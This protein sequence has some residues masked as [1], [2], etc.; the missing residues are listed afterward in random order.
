MGLVDLNLGL[1]LWL[2][3]L[4]WGL[5]LLHL[6]LYLGL[7]NSA[8]DLTWV[9][10]LDLSAMTSG[11]DGYDSGTCSSSF[12]TWLGTCCFLPGNAFRTCSSVFRTCWFRPW[13]DLGLVHLHVRFVGLTSDF[14][15]L[16]WDLFFFLLEFTCDFLVLPWDLLVLGLDLIFFHCRPVPLHVAPVDLD[17]GFHLWLVPLHLG[18]AYLDGWSVKYTKQNKYASVVS[19]TGQMQ[20]NTKPLYLCTL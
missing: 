18:L 9:L 11:L 2:V 7:L 15:V 4:D 6:G 19:D 1:A 12:G 3:S 14:L 8:C 10:T 16:T 5:V 13:L 17:L 20:I